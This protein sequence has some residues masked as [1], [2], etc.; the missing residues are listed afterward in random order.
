MAT[1]YPIGTGSGGVG[2]AMARLEIATQV[3]GENAGVFLSVNLSNANSPIYPQSMTLASGFNSITVPTKAG[4]VVL[5]PPAGNTNSLVLKGITG[6]TGVTLSKTAPTMLSF[7]TTPPS[8]I[9]IT[10][11]AS[12]SDF[13]CYW[14]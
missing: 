7:D 6:D 10:A 14:F 11:G 4:G 12:T 1:T 3:N 13:R 9:G 5:V 8:T 2:S